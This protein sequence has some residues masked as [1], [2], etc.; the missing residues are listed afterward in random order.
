MELL[1]GIFVIFVVIAIVG[2]RSKGETGCRGGIYLEPVGS[3]ETN[4][5]QK[6]QPDQPTAKRD[7]LE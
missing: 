2:G 4:P 3:H 6:R 7:P 1:I 5:F